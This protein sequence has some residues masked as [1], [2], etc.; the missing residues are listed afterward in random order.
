V[1][2]L[3]ITLPTPEENL[4]IDEALLLGAEADGDAEYLRVW[5]SPDDF[6]VLGKNCRVAEDVWVENCQS[7]EVPVLRR[8][9]GGGTV[10]LGPGCLNYTLVLRLDQSAELGGVQSS[11]DYILERSFRPLRAIHQSIGRAGQSDLMLSGRKFCGNAQ[12]RQRTHLLHHGSVLYAFALDK[13]PRYLKEP[14]R[15]PD[16]RS[17]RSHLDFLTNLPSGREQLRDGLRAA[18]NATSDAETMPDDLV[19]KLVRERYGQHEWNY[20]R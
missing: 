16:Y 18:W 11:F 6:A 14:S 19:E 4:A 9:S 2:F 3:D 10:L 5:E 8:I 20:R 13:I 1:Y 15:Q 7:D 12:R 17:R